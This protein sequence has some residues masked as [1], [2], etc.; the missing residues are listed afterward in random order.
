MTVTDE[1]FAGRPVPTSASEPRLAWRQIVPLLVVADLATIAGTGI[2]V[3]AA[4][5]LLLHG[6]LGRIVPHLSLPLLAAI[7]LVVIVSIRDGYRYPNYLREA[8]P[9]TSLWIAWNITFL[10]VLAVLFLLKVGS[11][12]SRGSVLGLYASGLPFL[13]LVRH[14]LSQLLIGKTKTGLL[15]ARRIFLVGHAGAIAAV[16]RRSQPWN[17]GFAVVGSASLPE[18]PDDDRIETALAEVVESV[19]RQA[20]DDVLIVLPWSQEPLIQRTVDQLRLAPSAIQVVPPALF[21][22]YEQLEI[23]QNGRLA[24]LVV[25]HRPLSSLDH[26]V[27]RGFDIVFALAALIVLSPVL[28]AAA[29]AIRL[30]S[31]APVLFLQRRHGFNQQPFRIYK[32]RSMAIASGNR[33]F[34]SATRNDPRVTPVG[35]FL[36]RTSIDELPQLI[37]VLKGDMSIVGPRPHATAQNED[38]EQR[39]ALYARRH[40]M[41]P[42]ITGWAQVHGLRGEID[43]DEKMRERV[44][45]DLYYLDNWSLVLDL[46]IILMTV[47]SPKV[48]SNAY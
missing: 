30:E 48:F 38:Y 47:L 35:R 33:G 36:R 19:R 44:R 12:I 42:G 34:Q 41:K 17:D 10:I 29:L 5:S 28:I 32:F 14:S 6:G 45:Y 37:N 26:V 21:E 25:S 39:I 7:L 2:V 3:S 11:G 1:S 46:R 22:S 8:W 9:S 24:G 31:G 15:A 13:Y 18:A 40:N 23:A 27:K 16:L 4:Y 20:P 43:S